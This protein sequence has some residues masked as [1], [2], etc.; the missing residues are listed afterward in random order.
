MDIILFASMKVPTTIGSPKMN[1]YLEDFTIAILR[2]SFDEMKNRDIA[3]KAGAVAT[4]ER[5]NNTIIR[6]QAEL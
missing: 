1:W 5:V 4:A 2:E 6:L 3:G